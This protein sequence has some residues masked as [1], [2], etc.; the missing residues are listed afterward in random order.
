MTSEKFYGTLP[1]FPAGTHQ[2]GTTENDFYGFSRKAAKIEIMKPHAVEPRRV[3]SF[4]QRE[5]CDAARREPE[6]F[7]LGPNLENFIE[8][9]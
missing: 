6:Q 9:A 8:V 2:P 1:L 4:G 3:F 5:G 7:C